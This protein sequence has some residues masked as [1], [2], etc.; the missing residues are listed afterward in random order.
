VADIEFL[1]RL[2]KWRNSAQLILFS[3]LRLV[4]NKK[5]KIRDDDKH[6]AIFQ[7]LVG[8]AFSL[9][10]AVFLA[11]R[12]FAFPEAAEAAQ[13]FLEKVVSDNAIGYMDEKKSGP[14]TAG[15]YE[16]HIQYRLYHLHK[17]YGKDLRVA[18]LDDFVAKWD[19]FK[20]P[21]VQI[22]DEIFESTIQCLQKLTARLGELLG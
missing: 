18:E 16:S 6:S 22:K 7:L 10:R 8:T 12:P 4:S 20:N 11:D 1:E 9:W 17:M 15:F 2:T 14:W 21:P 3:L 13:A 5:S 19:P